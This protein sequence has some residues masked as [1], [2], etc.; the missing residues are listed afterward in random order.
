MKTQSI[1]KIFILLSY[2]WLAGMQGYAQTPIK[3][4]EKEWKRVGAFVK[5]GLPKSALEEVKKIYVL[6][7]KENQDAQ[8]IKTLVYMAGLQSENRENN[9][10]FS[11]SEIEK[12]IAVSKEPVT[13]ILKSLLAE[14]YWNYYVQH[15]WQIYRRTETVNFTKTDIATWGTEDFHRRISELY[16]QSISAEK[17]LQQT[18][19]EPFDAIIIR[20]N[21]R[22]LRPTLYD[23]L[24]FRALIY[25][26]NDEQDI[27]KP[28]YAFE[29]NQAS[30]FDPADEFVTR[31]FPTRDSFSLQHKALLL[32]QKL[33]AFHLNDQKPDA[34]IDADL[35]RIAF[36]KQKSVHTDK[37]QLYFNAVNRIARRYENLPAAAQAWYLIAQYYD[38]Q[39]DSYKPFGDTTHRYE[40]VKAKD[41]CEKILKQKDSSEGRVNCFNLLN[42]I[43]QRSLEFSIEKVNLPGQPFRA[44]VKYRNFNTLYLRMIRADQKLK[45]QLANQSDDKYWPMLVAA[46][47]LKSWQQN[48][49]LT[50][51]YQQHSTEIKV[52]SLPPG[53][54]ILLA[55]DKPDLS[56]SRTILG[57]RFFYVSLISYVN[58]GNDFFVLNRDNG[59]PLSKATVQVWEQRYDY[60]LSKYIKE[61]G[62]AY[63][64]D[65][66]GFFRM[67]KRTRENNNY[68]SYSY[69]L[70]VSFNNE[71]LFMDDLVSEYYY[72]NTAPEEVKPITSLFFFTD[73]SLYRPGQTVYFK[74]IVVT[75]NLIEKTGGVLT[76]Y[77]TT[78][79][80]RD[81]NYKD[82]DSLKIK[83]NEY[84][85]FN[86][87]FS[88]PQTGL[89][90]Q[91]SIHTK[92]DQGNG[93]FKV[94]EYKRPKFYV[95]YEPI[96]GTYKVNDKIKITGIAKA[97]A[98][99]NIDGATV[100]YRVV[101]KPRFIYPWLFWRWWQPPSE[102]MEIVQGEI[103]TDKD[104]KFVVEFT[105]IPDMKIDRKFEPVFDYFVYADVTDING[106]TRNGEKLVSVSYKSLILSTNVPATLPADSLKTLSVHT[107]NM[108][109]EYEPSIVK[110]SFTKLKE[111]KRLIR[112][113]Y[114]ERPDQ[115]VM[116]KDEYIRIFPY[117]EYDNETDYKSWEKGQRIFEKSDSARAN[118]QWQVTSGKFEPGF[119]M[120]EFS[121]KDKNGEEVKD[122]KYIELYDENSKQLNRPDYLWAGAKKTVVEPGESA[123]IELGTAADN[124]FVVQ[125]VNRNRVFQVAEHEYS[126]LKLS[127]EKKTFSFEATERDR[128]AYP[129]NWMFIKHNRL[130]Q[131]NESINVPWTN[132]ELTVEYVSFRDKTLP[133]SEEKWK[134]RI[135]GY[136]KDKV[137]AEMLAG[138]YDAS[139]DQ[140]YPHTWNRPYIWYSS[141]VNINWSGNMNFARIE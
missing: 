23:F 87:K 68:S 107:Q 110:V 24:T 93:F 114:W 4:Y 49:P 6:A 139:L 117:D 125:Q 82:I 140:F 30:A 22:H 88:L 126:F 55:A 115:F 72:S 90:G 41:I 5:K 62:K 25:F 119:Y 47:P 74:G 100:K 105:A 60:K 39:A 129:V 70:D 18:K 76:G 135:T 32:Y 13:A 81:A 48:L 109:G 53:E 83:T 29:I 7:K 73:R 52:E 121:T 17:M 97:Y 12:E 108:N 11:I 69:L 132:K 14:M 91:F 95:D 35:Q 137:A 98:G 127:D 104:G 58:T 138:M 99:N 124:L 111:E 96:K 19:L 46:A 34:L 65:V 84:G 36:V 89:N 37:D 51:D 103:K 27:K 42:Q 21:T 43:N 40:R 128:G 92:G 86:G 79:Y 85:S 44:L 113:R 120:V 116:T 28:A 106:E 45:D 112:D 101:R 63:T 131:L 123:K 66:N 57:A 2:I 122:V 130:Y 31:K 9:E 75:R 102:E 78:V 15:R 64:T 118:G 133:G 33:L 59:Q 94:E 54:Y 3:K 141:Y 20:G 8:V 67:E 26:E 1:L 61:K 71:H 136:K 77:E 56:G 10:L 50:N 16:L 38:D 80:L 134:I